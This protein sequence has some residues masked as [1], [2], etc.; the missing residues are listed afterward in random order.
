MGRRVGL[1][2]VLLGLALAGAQGEAERLITQERVHVLVGAWHSSVTAPT[3]Q[4]AERF[5]ISFVN[6]ESSPPLSCPGGPIKGLYV[7]CPPGCVRARCCCANDSP[8]YL[9]GNAWSH[10]LSRVP[11]LPRPGT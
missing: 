5:G 8:C 3:S 11:G 6:T 4:V 7:G 1:L 9:G 2:S 10:W